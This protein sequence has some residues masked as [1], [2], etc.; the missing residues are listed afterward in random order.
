MYAPRLE[1]DHV[2]N[3]LL[4]VSQGLT[5]SLTVIMKIDLVGPQTAG[6]AMG[7]ERVRRLPGGRRK[8]ARDG[9]DRGIVRAAS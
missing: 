5:W 7:S 1:L 6:L 4:G 9:L 2:A 3:V 8:R